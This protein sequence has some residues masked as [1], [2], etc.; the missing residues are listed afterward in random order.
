MEE[1]LLQKHMD[2]TVRTSPDYNLTNKFSLN[3]HYRSY[4]DEV[5]SSVKNIETSSY[6]IKNCNGKNIAKIPIGSKINYIDLTTSKNE[7]NNT[8][9]YQF[10]FY[11]K[12]NEIKIY[13]KNGLKYPIIKIN[14]QSAYERQIIAGCVLF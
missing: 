4:K 11:K 7:L 8:Y 13:F 3:I 12:M 9:V 10:R 6:N 1:T 5:L 14:N 2:I